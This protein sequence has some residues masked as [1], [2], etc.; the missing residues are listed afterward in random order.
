MAGDGW[1]ANDGLPDRFV[2]PERTGSLLLAVFD[3]EHPTVLRTWLA[4]YSD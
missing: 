1:A 3:N 2:D 4:E